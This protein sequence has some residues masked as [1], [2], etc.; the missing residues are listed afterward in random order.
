MSTARKIAP[1]R[2]IDNDIAGRPI[3][4]AVAHRAIDD[5]VAHRAIDDDV[6]LVQRY[7]D[8]PAR[9]PDEVRSLV[10]LTTRQ[11]PIDAYA[12]IDLDAD[13]RLCER[14]LVLTPEWVVLHVRGEPALAARR[15]NVR[16]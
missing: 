6:E 15:S 4:D 3:D 13:L 10:A 9:L 16:R 12:L 8:Q 7:T 2:A 11:T 14:W 1:S 5:A